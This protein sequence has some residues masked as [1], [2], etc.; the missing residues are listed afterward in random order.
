MKTERKNEQKK[1]MLRN[2]WKKEWKKLE[3]EW[4]KIERKRKS[5]NKQKR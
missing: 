2:K 3:K 4:K 1:V 5:R